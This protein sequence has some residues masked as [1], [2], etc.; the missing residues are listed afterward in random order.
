MSICL[1]IWWFVVILKVN[2]YPSADDGA[3]AYLECNSF[4]AYSTFFRLVEAFKVVCQN[5]WSVSV[6]WETVKPFEES[7]R[8]RE[9]VEIQIQMADLRVS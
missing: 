1:A 2:R 4:L 8:W 5:L 7:R 3:W 6:E 9:R